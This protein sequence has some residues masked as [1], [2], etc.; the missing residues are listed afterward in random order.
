MLESSPLTFYHRRKVKTNIYPTLSSHPLNVFLLVLKIVTFAT[1]SIYKCDHVFMAILRA[2]L[3]TH[4]SE[5]SKIYST[6]NY[7]LVSKTKEHSLN[8]EFKV[9]KKALNRNDPFYFVM[10]E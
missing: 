4:L 3:C 6:L 9:V 5:T 1:S 2:E 10:K 8:W 7:K